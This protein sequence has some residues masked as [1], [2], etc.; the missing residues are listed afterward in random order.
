MRKKEITTRC[1]K[2]GSTDINMK[3]E[4]CK[5]RNRERKRKRRVL[6]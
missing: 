1:K 6:R 3:K 4:G 5:D 2:K